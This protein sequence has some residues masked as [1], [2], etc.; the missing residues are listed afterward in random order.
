[1]APAVVK[2]LS[3]SCILGHGPSIQVQGSDSLRFIAEGAQITGS[4]REW[5]VPLT[6]RTV[7]CTSLRSAI[8]PRQSEPRPVGTLFCNR[9]HHCGH[10]VY[11]VLGTGAAQR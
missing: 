8:G 10:I 1:V 11:L 2:R 6:E 4:S 7:G 3:L 5:I 9:P